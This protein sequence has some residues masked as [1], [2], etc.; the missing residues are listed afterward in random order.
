MRLASRARGVDGHVDACLNLLM[1]YYC[2]QDVHALVAI[3]LQVP[4]QIDIELRRGSG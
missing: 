1:L 3:S 2:S 4:P